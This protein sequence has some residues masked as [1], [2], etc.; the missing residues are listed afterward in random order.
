MN[1]L[2]YLKSYSEFVLDLPHRLRAIA[3]RRI[4]K[5]SKFT[6]SN[7]QS[8]S[9]ITRYSKIIWG[10]N[11]SEKRFRRFRRYY[12]YRLIL[13]HVD[14]NLGK[15]YLNRINSISPSFLSNNI[16]L[17]K[18]DT[19]GRPRKYQYP[20]AGSIS[21]T[22][23]RYIAVM[24]EIKELF[25]LKGPVSVAEIGIG[26][27]GQ[28][29]IFDSFLEIEKYSAFDLPQ[30][31]ELAERYIELVSSTDKFVKKDIYNIKPE[32]FDL[33]ISNYA[34]SELPIHI[35]REYLEKLISE[36]KMGFMIMNSGKSDLTGRS[37]GKISLKELQESIGTSEVLEEIPL[38]GP[39]N[40]LLI[41]G[42][43]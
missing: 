29:A 21:P 33:I 40:Y 2:M 43:A 23:L 19:I 13:E 31:L 20:I 39:D 16:Q 7:D 18:N 32:K 3:S 37:K 15:L 42:R 12:N 34:Y 28:F 10:F 17:I 30:V 4:N 36:S 11:E 14:F 38:T 6:Q 1:F 25:K 26:Y 22:T 9:E 24:L 8:D 41:W 5:R 27:G 35:Q